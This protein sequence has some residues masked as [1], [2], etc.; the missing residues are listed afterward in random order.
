MKESFRYP[1]IVFF[2]LLLI[3]CADEQEILPREYPRLRT[4]AV[5]EISAEG[6]TF[7]AEIF[8]NSEFEIVDHGFV[9]KDNRYYNIPPSLDEAGTASEQLGPIDGFKNFYFRVE[10]RLLVNQEYY[11]RAFVVTKDFTVYG[12]VV[13]FK[14]MGS[15]GN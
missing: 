9:W 8:S 3:G 7:N 11:V 12:N 2:F 6:A 13:S 15:K 5:T 10:D 1:A 14:S 4:L